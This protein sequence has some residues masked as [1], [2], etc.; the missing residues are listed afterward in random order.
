MKIRISLLFTLTLLLSDIVTAQKFNIGGA[1]HQM[2]STLN[3]TSS[4]TTS[5]DSN[6]G[7]VNFTQSEATDAIKAALTKGITEGV[8]KVS[9]T[10]GFFKNLAIKIPF[11]KEVST[12]ESTLRGIGLGSLIDKFVLSLNRAAEEAAKQATPIFVNAIKQMSITDAINIVNNKQSDAATQFLQRTTTEQLV[13][14][15]KP[16]IKTA[17]DKSLA[18]KYWRDITTH[19][20]KI[21]FVS[22][23]N[24]DLPDYATRKAI[25]G[26]FY[27]VAQEEA[28]IRK[29]PAG[30]ANSL[31][32]KVFGSVK[33]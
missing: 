32:E 3:G 27:M 33:F 26:L 20:N 21:P 11:P 29:D 19:Y 14:S 25:S 1:I 9:I 2:N 28:K 6:N 4:P 7:G 8:N 22:K 12:V 23:V 30:T 16:T 17:L 24:T 15:F 31:I 10:D 5:K 18:T 13:S